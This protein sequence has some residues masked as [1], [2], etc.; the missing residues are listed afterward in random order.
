MMKHASL[1]LALVL[2]AAMTATPRIVFADCAPVRPATAEEKKIYADG[3][4]L[5][6]RVVPP[7]PAGW[8]MNDDTKDGVLKEV[9]SEV[10]KKV[11]QHRFSRSYTAKDV[12]AR[13]AEAVK[14]IQAVMQ[15]SQARAKA[16]EAKLAE[17][18]KQME[19][20]QAKMQA[21]IA[22]TKYAEVEALNKQTEA[23]MQ[24]RMK[25]MNVNAQQEAM[26]AIGAETRRDTGAHFSLMF[27]VTDVNTSAFSPV[28]VGTIKA[29]RQVTRPERG[30]PGSADFMVVMGPAKGPQNVILISGD[31]ARAEA[32]LKATKFQ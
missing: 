1:H 22:A 17:N 15:E 18:T 7:A 14:K 4:A 12:V 23:L 24:E 19:A 28:T 9:C 10:N 16:N 31:Q 21:L 11:I 30:N 25:L 8:D 32:L 6:Q 3:Y 2:A 13:Q 26:D 5:F 20:L 29:L 27:N